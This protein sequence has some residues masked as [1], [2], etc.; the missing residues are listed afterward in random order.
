MFGAG[1]KFIQTEAVLFF[2]LFLRD[3]KVDIVL[4]DGEGGHVYEDKVTGNAGLDGMAFRA[5]PFRL[6]LIRRGYRI[7]SKAQDF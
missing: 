1:R 7:S 6:K 5:K 3:W 4:R 2:A